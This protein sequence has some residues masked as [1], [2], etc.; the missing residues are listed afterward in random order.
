MLDRDTAPRKRP[1]PSL[2]GKS[3]RNL[4]RW[5]KTGSEMV[6]E[7]DPG[8]FFNKNDGTKNLR[9]EMVSW[10]SG[11]QILNF[12]IEKR[13]QEMTSRSK[14]ISNIPRSMVFQLQTSVSKRDIS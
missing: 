3:N 5:K 4:C 1:S 13:I 11:I 12:V 8:I 6:E 9:S 2:S 10:A 7:G 14:N